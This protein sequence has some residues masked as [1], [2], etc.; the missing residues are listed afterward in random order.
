MK[1]DR[2]KNTYN[3]LYG[4]STQL[5]NVTVFANDCTNIKNNLIAISYDIEKIYPSISREIFRLK[6][7][8]F[9]VPGPVNPVIL[10]ELI[11]LLRFLCNSQGNNDF[12]DM[13][14]P[15]VI[16]T[17]KKL[18]EDGHYAN[19][20][21]DAFIEINARVKQLYKIINSTCE[22]VPDGDTVMTT[23]F[24]PNNPMIR[25]SDISTDTGKNIQKGYM[26]LFS[27]AISALRNP[28]AHENISLG[29][30]ECKQRLIF[31]SMLMYKLDEGVEYTGVHEN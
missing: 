21:E 5:G 31:A 20:A 13:V 3:W 8:L 7:Y 17:S 26:Q 30:E 14:H 6:D 2:I 10:G 25:F 19:S 11:A 27:G 16:K 15:M 23:M 18:F 9:V 22:K 28:K 24:S 29:S 1:L 12:W 4:L